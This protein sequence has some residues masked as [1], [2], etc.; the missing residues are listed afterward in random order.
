MRLLE[1]S[2]VSGSTSMAAGADGQQG[3]GQGREALMQSVRQLA[4]EQ[5]YAAAIA[6]LDSAAGQ[7]S[8][9]CAEAFQQQRLICSILL[10]VQQKEWWQVAEF[11]P[12]RTLKQRAL[13]T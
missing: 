8:G 9:D 1:K 13:S 7:E 4:E 12:A 10:H 3:A 5:R 2:G 6:L 11:R